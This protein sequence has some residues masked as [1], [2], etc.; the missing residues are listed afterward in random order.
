MPKNEL[1]PLAPFESSEGSQPLRGEI[2]DPAEDY[3]RRYAE[4]S[5]DAESYLETIVDDSAARL[6]IYASAVLINTTLTR[7]RASGEVDRELIRKRI[8]DYKSTFKKALKRQSD[9]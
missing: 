8:E 3:L 6:A 9:I 4:D 2:M 7:F 1:Q 5:E